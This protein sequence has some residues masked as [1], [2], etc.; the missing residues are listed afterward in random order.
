M[1]FR[2]W[3]QMPAVRACVALILV[4]SLGIIFNADG[5]FFKLGTHR[6]A[7][8]QISVYGCLACGMTLVVIA[9]GIDLAVGSVLALVAVFFSLTSIHWD[10]SPWLSVGLSL[11]VGA[12]CGAVSGTLASWGRFQP[13]IATLAVMV[14]ARGF[15]KTIGGGQKISTAIPGADDTYRYVEVPE[16]FRAIDSRIL[17]DNLSVVTLIF[18]ACFAV[19]WLLLSKHRWGRELYAIGGNEEAARLSGVPVMKAKFMAYVLSGIFAAVAGL[20]QAA[21]EQQGDPEAGSGYELTAIAIVVIGGTSLAGGRGGVGLTLVGM[22]T[23]GYLEKILSINAVPESTRLILTGMII[24][25][26]V[27][28]QR[29]RSR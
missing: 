14:A 25:L 22:L 21:Q 13:F 8:R 3:A 5:A 9:G 11:A 18:L 7:L 1:S 29:S 6:D 17:G 27:L 16:V 20:C 19:T 26:A 24:A 15:A 2:Q 28:A 23:I 4:L 10:W 12:A